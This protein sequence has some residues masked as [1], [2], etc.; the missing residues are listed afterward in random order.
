[1][2]DER[3]SGIWTRPLGLGP[4]CVLITLGVLTSVGAVSAQ[5]NAASK[6]RFSNRGISFAYPP[7][8]Y[9]TTK[10][11]SNG[12]E[13][14]YR[15]AVG[16]FRFHRTARDIGPCLQ[17][18]ASQRPKTGVLAFMREALGADARRARAGPRPYVFRLPRSSDQAACL[19]P[20]S[21]EVI[22]RAAG[23]IF[24]L[25]VSVAPKASALARAQLRLL[26]N[27]MK[28]ARA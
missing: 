11:L 19:G 24:Y 9:A 15:F 1:V 25:W 18:I 7:S 3:L 17:G 13:P 8:W 16:S 22:F 26:L 2:S 14:V 28:I 4:I 27:S 20:G 21:T 12:I 6:D 5:A 23:R 10:P